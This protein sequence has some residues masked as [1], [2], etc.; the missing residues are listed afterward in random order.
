MVDFL[1]FAGGEWL[2]PNILFFWAGPIP[3]ILRDRR[4]PPQLKN[5]MDEKV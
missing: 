1:G 3:G 4:G 5:M 2:T